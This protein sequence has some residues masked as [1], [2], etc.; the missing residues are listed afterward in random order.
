[1]NSDWLEVERCYGG[2]DD[3]KD[4]CIFEPGAVEMQATNICEQYILA[5][6]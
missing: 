4:E 6:G 2:G 1:M 5:Q 3:S